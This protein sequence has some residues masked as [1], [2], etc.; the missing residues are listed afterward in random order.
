MDK[1]SVWWRLA[2]LNPALWRMLVTAVFAVASALGLTVVAGLDEKIVGLIF[3]LAMIVQ[4]V[5][6]RRGVTA[7]ARV[8]SYLPDPVNRPGRILPGEAV[9]TAPPSKI[10]DAARDTPQAA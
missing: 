5:W 4:A 2:N 10:L 7:N 6:T 9:T 3:V 8:V 1:D